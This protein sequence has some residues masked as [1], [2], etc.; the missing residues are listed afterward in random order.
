M[1]LHKFP[2][3]TDISRGAVARTC[4]RV[5]P[6][7]P[8]TFLVRSVELMSSPLFL[9]LDSGTNLQ[10]AGG[11][12]CVSLH[13]RWGRRDFQGGGGGRGVDGKNKMHRPRGERD[14]EVGPVFFLPLEIRVWK[15]ATDKLSIPGTHAKLLT[16]PQFMTD[17]TYFVLRAKCVRNSETRF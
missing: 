9:R 13:E 4:R 17:R 8:C 15:I 10:A 5:G 14:F 3:H 7:L 11:T 2:N 16:Q 1:A 6:Y 12:E